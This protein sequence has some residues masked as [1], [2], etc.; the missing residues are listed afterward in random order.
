[1][2]FLL[3]MSLTRNLYPDTDFRRKFRLV[4]NLP[5]SS[6]ENTT[7]VNQHQLTPY[8]HVWLGAVVNS[9]LSFRVEAL[10]PAYQTM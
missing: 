1:M 6:T 9:F 3:I 2:M 4:P 5:V 8:Q 10:E 7:N